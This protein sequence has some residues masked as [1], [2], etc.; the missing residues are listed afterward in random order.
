MLSVN[1]SDANRNVLCVTFYEYCESCLAVSCRRGRR[2]R[3]EGGRYVVGG[4]AFVYRNVSHDR[5]E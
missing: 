3:V 1:P 5:L 2:W 4:E